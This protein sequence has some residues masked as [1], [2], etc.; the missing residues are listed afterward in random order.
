MITGVDLVQAQLLLALEDKYDFK[1]E[2]L[3][4]NGHAMQC[5]IN[6][7]DPETFVPSPGRIERVH[8]P[9]GYHVRF[10]SQIYSGY[11]VPA[12]YD[13]LIAEVIVKDKDRNRVINKMRVALQELVVEG[14]KTN[15]NLHQRILEDKGFL[16]LD[17]YIKYLEEELIK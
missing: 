16:N 13:S 6:A 3:K 8:R 1:Q 11:K 12:N 15:Q 2:D 17:Y 9:G 14:I 7:E 4:V 10:E 5:R